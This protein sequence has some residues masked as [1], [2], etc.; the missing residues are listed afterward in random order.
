[1]PFNYHRPIANCGWHHRI[2]RVDLQDMYM[3]SHLYMRKLLSSNIYDSCALCHA[4]LCSVCYHKGSQPRM[5]P[6]TVAKEMSW[7]I[8]SR[9]KKLG[10]RRSTLF[11]PAS[12]I[13][14]NRAAPDSMLVFNW[15]SNLAPV[16][17]LCFDGCMY[18]CFEPV[19]AFKTG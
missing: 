16:G 11:L 9:K 5:I 8:V 2:Y 18:V 15:V 7:L 14:I 10:F 19:V 4:L 3:T 1:M 6:I 12:I 13:L 17:K